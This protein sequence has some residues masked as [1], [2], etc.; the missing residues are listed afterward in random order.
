MEDEDKQG[1]NRVGSTYKLNAALTS[2]ASR[3]AIKNL[4][5]QTLN[6]A[7]LGDSLKIQAIK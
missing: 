2:N 1:F 3:R 5:N 4:V 7:R 6:L